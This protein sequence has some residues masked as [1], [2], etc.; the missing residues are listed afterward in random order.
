MP[1]DDEQLLA[2]RRDEHR[3]DP[4]GVSGEANHEAAVVAK[5]DGARDCTL[6]SSRFRAHEE[7]SQ[8]LPVIPAKSRDP[9]RQRRHVT[10]QAMDS[11]FRRND[12]KGMA[13]PKDSRRDFFTASFAAMTGLSEPVQSAGCLCHTS[14]QRG[15]NGAGNVS[16]G[17]AE[18]RWRRGA[19]AL[20]AALRRGPERARRSPSSPT[21]SAASTRRG[22]GCSRAARSGRRSF[23]AG[24]LPDFLPETKHDPRR[25]LEGRADPG[26]PARPPRRDHRPGRPQDDRQRAEFRRQGLHGRFRGRHLADL[27]EPS[28]RARS[29]SRT[30]GPARSTSPTRRAAR[31]TSSADSP[32]VLLVRPRGWH[33]PEEHLVVDGEPMSGSLFDFGLYFFHN[34][35]AALG[36]GSGPYFYLPKMESHL[37]A[38]LWNE[39]FV[40]AAAGA[41][42]PARHDQ[43]DGADRDAAGRLRDGRDPLR[44]ARPHGRAQLR[45][46]G[47]HL[48]LHQDAR[49]N[50]PDFLLP[51][52]GQVVMGK[53]FLQAY[54]RA[55]DQD[56]PPP[57]RLRHGRHGG[58]DP[59]PQ[60]TRRSTRRPSP[61]CAPTRSARPRPAMTAP[62]WRI[63]TSCRSPMEVFDR[64]MPQ[65]NQLDRLR[66]D[67]HVGAEGPARGP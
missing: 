14:L 28:S 52:R 25:R 30:A 50:K 54:S 62:G 45:P 46:L 51:D 21:C 26:R 1:V 36:R 44:A 66:E 22:C 34:A 4:P 60:A 48:L 64:L 67:V 29:T 27:G 16:R 57:R 43:G 5:V 13:W 6:L 42:P 58:A 23:D 40:H 63:P 59:G 55:P 12:E 39:V 37:E 41:R 9:L 47:L 31:T 3:A 53:A 18:G 35:K 61:R 10:D 7:S 20:G 49:A 8:P 65:P 38:R 56:L 15:M 17:E 11:G 2:F 24:E 19:R 33:L 32:A